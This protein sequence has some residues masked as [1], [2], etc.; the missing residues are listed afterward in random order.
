MEF[1]HRSGMTFKGLPYL[2]A[3]VLLVAAP[4]FACVDFA[5]T[6]T[7]E[8]FCRIKQRD[9][10]LLPYSLKDFRKNP[11]ATQQLLLKRPAARLGIDLPVAPAPSPAAKTPPLPV[12]PAR[13]RPKPAAAA[14]AV[15]TSPS[16]A[17]C[18]LQ[19][20]V[21]TCGGTDYRLL[22]N[23]NDKVSPEQVSRVLGEFTPYTG[24]AGDDAAERRYLAG[25]YSEYIERM[26]ALGLAGVTLSYTKFYHAYHEAT[27]RGADFSKRLATM[28]R[29]LNQDKSTMA[30]AK[31]YGGET[32]S[33]LGQCQRLNSTFVVC[34]N[35]KT[36]WVYQKR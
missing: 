13:A 4:A 24:G 10:T 26:V 17:G 35:V 12:E 8:V 11:V 1:A 6:P 14:A 5:Q 36:N 9:A 22:E 31:S 28:F 23:R 3:G 19:T 7:E 29:F 32:P 2:L 21:I 34:D 25:I 33:D 20:A 18:R 30:V 15:E 16:L 27:A